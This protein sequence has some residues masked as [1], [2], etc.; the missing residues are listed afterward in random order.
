MNSYYYQTTAAGNA[1][2]TAVMT[3]EMGHALGLAHWGGTP[4]GPPRSCSQ[5]SIM[6]ADVY[7][8][9]GTPCQAIVPS[10]EDVTTINNLYPAPAK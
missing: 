7:T 4:E 9:Y 10:A 5:T 2:Y 8:S 6:R 3:H 1:R